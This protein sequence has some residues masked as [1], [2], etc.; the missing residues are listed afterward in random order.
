MKKPFTYLKPKKKNDIDHALATSTSEDL[1]ETL[2]DFFL[3]TI[4]F[5]D[6]DGELTSN[7]DPECFDTTRKIAAE[8]RKR[9]RLPSWYSKLEENLPNFFENFM[10]DNLKQTL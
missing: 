10:N 7:S 6:K 2:L 8:L 1:C 5:G 4:R 9:G 3:E